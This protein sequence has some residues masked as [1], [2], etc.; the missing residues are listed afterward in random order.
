MESN[1][2]RWNWIRSSDGSKILA[3]KHGVGK[4]PMSINPF[5]I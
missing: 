2:R 1:L 4:M 3:K 5:K